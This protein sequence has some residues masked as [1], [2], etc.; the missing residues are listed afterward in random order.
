MRA[1]R[2]TPHTSTSEAP[3]LLML[4]RETR[5]PDH[6]TYHVPEQDYSVHEYASE[7]VERMKVAHEMLR[8]KQWQVQRE[9]SEE[10][11]LYQIGDWVW[12]VNYRRRRGQ[13]AKL[14]PKFVGPYAVVEV[15][16]NHTY[17]IERSGQVSIQN[18]VCLKPYWASPDAV[19]EAPPSLLEP[20]RQTTTWGRQ[21]TT[22][23][24]QRHRPEYEVVV[25]RAEDLAR[26]ERPLPLTEV[27]PPSLA[28]DLM[29]PLPETKS[30]PEV[31]NPPP[32]G[33]APSGEVREEQSEETPVTSRPATLPVELD[34]PPVSTPP[35]LERGQRTRQ[36][37]AYLKDFVCDCVESGRYESSAGHRT[38]RLTTEYGS[39]EHHKKINFCPGRIT[40]KIN[41]PEAQCPSP[42]SQTR[43]PVFSYADAVKSRRASSH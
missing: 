25:L 3:N 16:P 12:M 39:C 31:Q 24:R 23:G 26:D 35:L 11:P 9:D 15:M 43:C 2:S 5:V 27:R 34:S 19:G 13:A 1:Y 22:R 40:N 6:L 7:L 10:P 37:P 42:A 17:K 33:G 30:D 38:E 20:R 8:E 36:P 18:E 29:P 32:G 41:L 4:G 14:Q 21:T 28:P